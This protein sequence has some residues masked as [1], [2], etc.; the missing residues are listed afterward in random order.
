[1]S[2][3]IAKVV[4][5]GGGHAA[6]ELA[7]ALRQKG[8]GGAIDIVSEEP[9][10]P[11]QRPPLSKDYMKRPGNP[12]LLRPEQFYSSQAI[13][14]H[15]GQRVTSINRAARKVH[16]EGGSDLSY[17]HLV[18]ATGA[19][20][21]KPE[22][23][24]IDHPD[25]VELRTLADAERIVARIGSW[26]R[27]AI[28]GGGFIG[29]E[30]AGLFAEMGIA[31]DVVELAPRL[32]QR[33][34]SPPISDWFL[35]FHRRKGVRFHMP[36]RVVSIRHGADVVR[37]T[38]SDRST[39]ETDAVVLAAGV[40]PNT[41]LAVNAG[42]AVAN[43]IVVDAHLATADPSVSAVG[44]CACFPSSQLSLFVRLESVQNATDQGR[45]L[46]ARLVGETRPYTA[47]PWFW[48]IQGEA[49]LQ[50]AGLS[51]PGLTEVIRGSQEQGHFSVFLFEGNALR[52]VESV[53]AA[54]DHM[55]SRR[56]LER[57][58]PLS[59]DLAADEVFDL[60]ALIVS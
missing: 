58:I 32:M 18:L 48:S 14:L 7:A 51:R 11:Y 28:I 24:G 15:S 16:M 17:D 46:A 57:S 35:E 6:V 53:N 21:L 1:M 33:A 9:G 22:L 42:L 39:I 30:A 8:F 12:L 52:A 55:V 5:V 47:L 59:P 38:L 40:V 27:V 19:R 2:E 54:G 44:D 49:R 36:R 50:I 60:K 3:M 10:L 41:S 23:S 20:N 45:T 13:T 4:V 26:K 37:L 25:V 56:L 31:V 34:V 29:L 43:G